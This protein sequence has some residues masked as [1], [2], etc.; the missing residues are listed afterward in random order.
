MK[1]Y[2]L[3]SLVAIVVLALAGGA[4]SFI[5]TDSPT[6]AVTS[7]AAFATTATTASTVQCVQSCDGPCVPCTPEECAALCGVDLATAKECLKS[8]A[9][10][11]TQASQ[12]SAACS[13]QKEC[14]MTSA[15]ATNCGSG[16]GCAQK[17]L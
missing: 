16:A 8:A 17:S 13:T 2:R 15:K 1:N 5:T 3:F 7:N 11:T 6:Q 10:Q 14:K 4:A 12:T 9:C